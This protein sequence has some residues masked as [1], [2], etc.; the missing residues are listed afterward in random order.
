MQF[1]SIHLFS[2]HKELFPP[3]TYSYTILI[4]LLMINAIQ[5]NKEI[6]IEQ[7]NYNKKKDKTKK[8]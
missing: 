1:N 4:L 6:F 8:F 3:Y 7:R 2:T 5:N